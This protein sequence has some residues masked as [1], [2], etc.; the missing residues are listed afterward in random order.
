MSRA[1][2]L[3]VA[4]LIVWSGCAASSAPAS[5]DAVSSSDT[6]ADS[7]NNTPQVIVGGAN[8]DGTGFVDWSSGLARPPIVTGI[9][10]GQ[11]VFVS[12]R[13]RNLYPVQVKINTMVAT[14]VECKA[15]NPGS[16]EWKVSLR[17]DDTWLGYQGITA[18]VDDPCLV[19]D[20]VVRVKVEVTDQN[21]V[22]ASAYADIQPTWSGA[23]N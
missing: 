5:S 18:F 13:T 7:A 3:I 11:H 12:V 20:K 21:N 8:D 4:G 15:Y 6:S 19:K 9:Q 10:G 16:R 14:P 2:L 23:C 17:T 1:H 22:T